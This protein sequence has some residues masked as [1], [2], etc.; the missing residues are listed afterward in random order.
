MSDLTRALCDLAYLTREPANILPV[1]E[2]IARADRLRTMLALQRDCGAASLALRSCYRPIRGITAPQRV[3]SES[4]TG[5]ALGSRRVEL[6]P[7]RTGR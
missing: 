5:Q 7:R 4:A 1:L 2:T 3:S 6:R